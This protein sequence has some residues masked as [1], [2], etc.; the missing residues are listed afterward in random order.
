MVASTYKCAK[1]TGTRDDID[2]KVQTLLGTLTI[3]A[4]S[5]P[6]ISIWSTNSDNFIAVIV[7]Q[8]T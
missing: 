2:S 1:T 8:E 5:S 3:K 6:S 7:Y 4:D